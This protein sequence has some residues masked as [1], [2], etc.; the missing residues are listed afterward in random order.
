MNP[1][2][3]KSSCSQAFIRLALILEM[4]TELE[5][6]YPAHIWIFFFFSYSKAACIEVVPKLSAKSPL[7]IQLSCANLSPPSLLHLKKKIILFLF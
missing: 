6:V 2:E 7:G 1:A 3:P 5:K 4:R